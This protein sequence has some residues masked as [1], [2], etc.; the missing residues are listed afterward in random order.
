MIEDKLKQDNTKVSTFTPIKRELSPEEIKA[1]E[2]N[3]NNYRRKLNQSWMYDLDK[4][5]KYKQLQDF[6]NQNAFG[7][8]IQGTPTR[9]NPASQRG[10]QL[11]QSNLDYSKNNSLD[12]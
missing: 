2:Y 5:N 1:R 9:Y 4:T 8:G 3:A 6:Y 12:F 7:Y 10:R 11:I